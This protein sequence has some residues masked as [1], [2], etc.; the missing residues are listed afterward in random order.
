MGPKEGGEKQL[1]RR[2]AVTH[3]GADIHLFVFVGVSGVLVS[4]FEFSV[5]KTKRTSQFV[6]VFEPQAC[7]FFFLHFKFVG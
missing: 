7:S 3:G 1:V 6:Y 2:R 5:S 4:N